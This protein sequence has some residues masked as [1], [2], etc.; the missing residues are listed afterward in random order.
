MPLGW[1]RTLVT[2]GPIV[3]PE[4][5]SGPPITLVHP[6]EDRW[7]SAEVSL[8]FHSRLPGND[9]TAH[10]LEGC[11]HFPVE[12]PGFSRMLEVLADTAEAVV[13]GQG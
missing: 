5:Y 9:H 1:Y 11:G 2:V 12:E 13:R 6:A 8:A 4:K 7:T 3:T 10:L